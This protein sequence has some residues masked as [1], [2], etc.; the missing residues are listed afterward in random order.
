MTYLLQNVEDILNWHEFNSEED[1]RDWARDNILSSD[2][3]DWALIDPEG[4]DWC[5]R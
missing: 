1:A 5:L 3:N 2:F 4:M